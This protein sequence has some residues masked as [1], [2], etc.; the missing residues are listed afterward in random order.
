[1]FLSGFA[2][3]RLTVGALSIGLGIP[4]NMIIIA[5]FTR[6]SI[7]NAT[8][9]AFIALAVVDLVGSV[10]NGVKIASVFFH[11]E[12]PWAC[13]LEIIGSRSALFAGLLLTTSIAAYRYQ[14]V[15]NPFGKRVGRWAA[16]WLSLTCTILA[17][18]IHVPFFF[19]TTSQKAGSGYVCNTYGN[20]AWAQIVYSRSQA[21]L[22]CAS[23]LPVT[24]LYV[25]ILKNIRHHQEIRRKVLSDKPVSGPKSKPEAM[26]GVHTVSKNL[27]MA[28]FSSNPPSDDFSSVTLTI[29][30]SVDPIISQPSGRGPPPSRQIVDQ[31][32]TGARKGRKSDH[33]TTQM[34]III[35]AVF[36][37][38]W[39]PSI[40]LDQ[41]SH[42]Q[43]GHIA[44]II[45]GTLLYF[46][47][48]IS[49][50]T[51]VYQQILNLRVKA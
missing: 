32:Q 19:I 24:V 6:Q 49:V 10:I 47:Y 11:D 48:Q 8:D 44:S 37:L 7:S 28:S 17:F 42:V 29:Q 3:L 41:L 27:K 20:I 34:L 12:H 43:I 4:G 2:I 26:G 33:K 13:F 22:F 31:A 39:L 40:I 16:A 15:C 9:V 21:V 51:A 5:V 35:T 1:M 36:F 23:A 46:L 30:P 14:A 25:L 38:L 50:T 18:A 45:S